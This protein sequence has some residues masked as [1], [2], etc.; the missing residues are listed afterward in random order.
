MNVVGL[1][2]I[3]AV[4]ATMVSVDLADSADSLGWIGPDLKRART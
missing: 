3:A 1:T 2:H 4:L